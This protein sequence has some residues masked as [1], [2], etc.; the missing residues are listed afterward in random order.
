MRVLRLLWALPGTLIGLLLSPFFDRR[1]VRDGILVCSGARWPARLGW[2][3]SAITFGHVVLATSP[4]DAST[5]A[6][7][8]AHVR[9]YE[10]W[11]PLFIPAY[12]IASIAM[13]VTGHDAYRDNPFEERARR[14]TQ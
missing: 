14:A 4:P 13:V 6:H 12:L 11:G 8:Q 5:W 1:E 3:Y 7:E 9:Q 2:H 10:L